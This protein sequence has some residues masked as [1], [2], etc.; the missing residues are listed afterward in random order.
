VI[1]AGDIGGTSTRLALFHADRDRVTPVADATFPSASLNGLG[2]TIDH[3]IRERHRTVDA[4]AFGIAGPVIDGRA[5]LPNLPWS[6]DRDVLA[7]QLDLARVELINDLEANAYGVAALGPE[8]LVPL[9]RTASATSGNAA[10]ISV[11]TG[12]GEAG[13]Y[14]DGTAH[15]PFASEG[16]H[17]DF[18]PRNELE[19]DL[20]KE[21]LESFPTV[22]Y[23]RVLSGAGLYRI[24][25]FLRWRAG[26]QEPQWLTEA[27]R[28]HAGPAAIS[29]AALE[30]SDDVAVAALRLFGSSLGAEA[31]NLA[32]RMMARAGVYV[33]GGIAPKILP[34]LREGAFMSAF[35]EK[36]RM[37]PLLETIPVWVIRNDKTA[38]LG[39]ARY[40]ANVASGRA[41]AL[42]SA[43]K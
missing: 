29:A 5:Q 40:A 23:E 39:A 20:L 14:W 4:A 30:D 41:E 19:A 10:I 11:G 1:L 3:F 34:M 31:G 27:A 21:L 42:T 2:E 9:N 13:L 12:L 33:G 7:R 35:V 17:A 24:Y 18:A 38:L 15:H 28:R 8:D 22:S 36:G 16:G 25:T 43:G 6:V 32:L 37:R 26:R